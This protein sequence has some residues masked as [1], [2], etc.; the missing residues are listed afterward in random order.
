MSRPTNQ[1]REAQN[2]LTA[3]QM[4]GFDGAFKV[5]YAKALLLIEN[6]VTPVVAIHWLDMSQNFLKDG[7]KYTYSPALREQK[8]LLS[9]FY[10]KLAHHIYWH[11]LSKKQV[12]A[13]IGF[14]QPVPCI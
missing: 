12:S 7:R 14:V 8:M 2:S 11:Q 9:R 6:E 10:W 5:A 1:V 4:W 3:I 13:V